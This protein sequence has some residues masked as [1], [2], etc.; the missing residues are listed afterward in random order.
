MER[1]GEKQ[2]IRGRNNLRLARDVCNTEDWWCV[3]TGVT[4]NEEVE[5]GEIPDRE[6]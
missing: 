1:V 2:K 6:K 5:R 4:G 3:R